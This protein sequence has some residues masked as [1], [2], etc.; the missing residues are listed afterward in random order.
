MKKKPKNIPTYYDFPGTPIFRDTTALPFAAGG[1]TAIKNNVGENDKVKNKK[2][3]LSETPGGFSREATPEEIN[4]WFANNQKMNPTGK[5][6]YPSQLFVSEDWQ[7]IGTA[8]R[9]YPVGVG[10]PPGV[11]SGGA[12]IAGLPWGNP[13][14]NALGQ[15]NNVNPKGNLGFL[16][17][18]PT[19]QSSVTAAPGNIKPPAS[20]TQWVQNP[21]TGTWYQ[22]E[23]AVKPANLQEYNLQTGSYVPVPE[24]E[25]AFA[26]GGPLN[27][28]TPPNLN[29]VMNGST[30]SFNKSKPNSVLAYNPYAE[31]TR[32]PNPSAY[33]KPNY[34]TPNNN[35]KYGFVQP[36]EG[37]IIGGVG[38]GIPKHGLE[39]N[40]LGVAP[41]EK[42]P[43]FKG[44][45][46]AGL[47]KQIGANK[48]GLSVGSP[49][50]G[51]TDE[52]GFHA[53]K[54]QLEPQINFKRTF[55]DG[56]PLVDKTN[57]GKLLNSVYAS[58][59]GDY[60][61]TGGQFP[62][63]YSLP[64]D[65]FKQGGRNLH[66][67][68]YASSAAQYPAVYNFGGTLK[69]NLATRQQMYMPLD[70]ITRTGGSILSM[71][72][73]PQLEGEGKDLA[74]DLGGNLPPIGEQPIIDKAQDEA[75][76]FA[77]GK[78]AD[79]ERWKELM[80]NT[81]A[82]MDTAQGRKLWYQDLK[83]KNF[84]I[85]ELQRFT[86]GV[87]E[88]NQGAQDYERARR[89]VQE[90]KISTDDFGRLYDEK[91]WGKFDQATMK[92][93]YQG[94]FQDA[95]DEAQ[96]RK[97]ANMGVT[98]TAL[99]LITGAPALFRVA[100]DPL[101]TI[102]GVGNTIADVAMS[103][104]PG[105]GAAFGAGDP[106]V[107]PLTGNQYWSG[108]DKALDVVGFIPGA[109]GA[110]KGIKELLKQGNR[111]GLE[112]VVKGK[113][114]IGDLFKRDDLVNFKTAEDLAAY[115]KA[116]AEG[117]LSPT[118]NRYYSSLESNPDAFNYA[119]GSDQVFMHRIPQ[120]KAAAAGKSLANL[121]PKGAALIAQQRSIPTV[122]DV[123]DLISTGKLTGYSDE[124]INGL[125]EVAANPEGYWNLPIFK[126]NKELQSLVAD[127]TIVNPAEHFLPRPA[128]GDFKLVSAGAIPLM[129]NPK[130]ID[131]KPVVSAF[132][133]GYTNTNKAKLAVAPQTMSEEEA[134]IISR[135]DPNR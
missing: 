8:G 58:A 9:T 117:T 52:A 21:T 20:K 51:Y 114:T 81:R 55:L 78:A 23:T 54:L 123:E 56:G 30:E 72:N 126:N 115:E 76:T 92:E 86:Q 39:G 75:E 45:Y 29:Q 33:I 60:Y 84:S 88:Y 26:D 67:S 106:N 73:T 104:N 124:T 118:R 44:F 5:H 1:Y 70:H 3:K 120:T 37:N 10:T 112:N 12:N 48:I 82:L 103:A 2:V 83:P 53:N 7:P 46:S 101:G 105:I 64:E 43:Y 97:E 94:Q 107:N 34:Y 74:Y 49:V 127:P 62:R 24:T 28:K 122:A 4:I 77:Y 89:K 90:G 38:Y 113:A 98:N 134:E 19:Q 111:L 91:G 59:L 116:V 13:A 68:I 63:P 71:S 125:R 129:A 99:E 41:A 18:I 119:K 36:T 100:Q 133:S 16:P 110:G 135:Q 22:K 87:K 40:L 131:I 32:T 14:T 11:T 93:G 80:D 42:N 15:P 35:Y 66:N 57:H 128:V 108:V 85:D 31:A 25:I 61:K 109:V 79:K 95:A 69:N 6:V 50:T 47:S 27:D 130:L 65:S 121:Q 132:E 96:K 17:V 102:A